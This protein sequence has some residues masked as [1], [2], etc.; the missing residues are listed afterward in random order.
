LKSFMMKLYFSPTVARKTTLF[1]NLMWV[2]RFWGFHSSEDS[3]QVLGEYG[4]SMDF[5]NIGILL[6]HYV[7]SATQKT[8]TWVYKLFQVVKTRKSDFI[9]TQFLYRSL[10]LWHFRIHNVY[11]QAV[12]VIQNLR[13]CPSVCAYVCYTFPSC[14]SCLLQCLV[15]WIGFI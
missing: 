6:Q 3:S 4:G 9:V 12:L 13:T 10:S 14:T 8:S 7:V 1:T 11:W 15:I 5:L 2:L